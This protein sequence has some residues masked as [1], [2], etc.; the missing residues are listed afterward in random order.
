MS[1]TSKRNRENNAWTKWECQQTYRNGKK[2]E[3][4]INSGPVEKYN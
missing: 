1:Q 3:P 4:K 2:K